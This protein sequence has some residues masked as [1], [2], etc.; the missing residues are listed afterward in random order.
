MKE[1][2]NNSDETLT[3]GITVNIIYLG[4]KDVGMWVVIVKALPGFASAAHGFR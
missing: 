1:I 4:T 2:N 3:F